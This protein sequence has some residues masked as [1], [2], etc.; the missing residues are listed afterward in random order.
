MNKINEMRTMI[1]KVK[2]YTLIIEQDN[3]QKKDGQIENN[4]SK[5]LI[6]ALDI[7]VADMPN[8]LN[9]IANQQGDKD[10]I[11]DAP[12]VYKF[13][14]QQ[15]VSEIKDG[16]ILEIKFDEN[17]FQECMEEDLI[18]EAGLLGLTLSAPAIINMTGKIASWTG[19]KLN[20]NW[21]QKFGD[22]MSHFGEKIHHKYIG[23]IEKVITPFMPNASKE[24]IHKVA[25]IA[26]MG[27]IGALFAGGLSNPGALEAVKGQELAS[28]VKNELPNIFSKI[29]F[30]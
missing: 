19:K 14:K 1:D 13:D 10:G 12:G 2:N 17:K 4:I 3:G 25:E 16:H 23:T 30:S 11:I 5:T 27:V 7:L 21:L 24:Q 20:T 8:I 18:K 29:G 28:F 26:L 6:Q 22:K 9:V 15:T